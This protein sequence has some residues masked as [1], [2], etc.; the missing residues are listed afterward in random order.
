MI[1]NWFPQGVQIEQLKDPGTTGNF[2]MTIGNQLVH[3]KKTRDE[4]F[5]ED[6]ASKQKEVKAIIQEALGADPDRLTVQSSG[7]F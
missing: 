4:G 2:E 7:G 6:N 1:L 5:F 3:S